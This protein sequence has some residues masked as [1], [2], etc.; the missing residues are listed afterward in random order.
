[1]KN[2]ETV[3]AVSGY[4]EEKKHQSGAIFFYK[5]EEDKMKDQVVWLLSCGYKEVF[6]REINPPKRFQS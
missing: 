5:D 3:Y 2:K 6:V 1:M 4:N